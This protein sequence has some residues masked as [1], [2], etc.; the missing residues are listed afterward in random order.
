MT[1]R[2]DELDRLVGGMC[3]GTISG[4]CPRLDSILTSDEQA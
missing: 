4:R 2:T 1:G 3:D